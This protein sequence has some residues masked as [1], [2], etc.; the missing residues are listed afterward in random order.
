MLEVTLRS[1][2]DPSRQADRPAVLPPRVDTTS[3]IIHR[4]DDRVLFR[5]V[6]DRLLR[7]LHDE[8]GIEKGRDGGHGRATRVGSCGR[9]GRG[10]PLATSILRFI[11]FAAPGDDVTRVVCKALGHADQAG[12]DGPR[13]S[14]RDRKAKT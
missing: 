1:E 7:P 10:R 2:V 4:Y 11:G 13:R 8:I 3:E 9:V 12:T 5:A 14:R 6:L